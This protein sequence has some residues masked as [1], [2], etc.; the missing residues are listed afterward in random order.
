[1]SN[2]YV[3]NNSVRRRI[4]RDLVVGSTILL[5]PKLLIN[6]LADEIRGGEVLR[7]LMTLSSDN[8]QPISNSNAHSGNDKVKEILDRIRRE[9][10]GGGDG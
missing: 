10:M 4:I 7:E 9:H 2:N 5:N 1:M 3:N 8:Q 6:T